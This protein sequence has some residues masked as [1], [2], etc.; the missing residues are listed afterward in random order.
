MD[1]ASKTG[2]W[3]MLQNCHLA[4][5]WMDDLEKRTLELGE[6]T[7]I[8]ADYRLFLTSM[9]APYF[10]VSTLQN[11]VKMTTEPPRGL[12]ANLKRTY[13]DLS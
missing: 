13:V 11:G 1:V 9:P 6:R 3:V 2:D 10:P 12:K 4:K 5:S 7:D 8:H